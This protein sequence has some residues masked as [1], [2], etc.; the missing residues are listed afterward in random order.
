VRRSSISFINLDIGGMS[1]VAAAKAEGND[2]NVAAVQVSTIIIFNI[3]QK[4][5]YT[6]AL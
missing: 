6:C 5:Q 4:I 2:Y 3:N 1:V